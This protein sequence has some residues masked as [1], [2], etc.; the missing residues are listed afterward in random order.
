MAKNLELFG[1]VGNQRKRFGRLHTRDTRRTRDTSSR[2]NSEGDT[3]PGRK[4]ILGPYTKI[5]H[6]AKKDREHG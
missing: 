5:E 6:L 2:I 4:T 3:K 1:T